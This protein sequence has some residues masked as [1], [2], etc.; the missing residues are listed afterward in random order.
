MALSDTV[1][2]CSRNGGLARRTAACTSGPAGSSWSNTSVSDL[3]VRFAI[4]YRR[5]RDL[6]YYLEVVVV[7]VLS[8][9][10]AVMD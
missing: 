10:A 8:I 1:L 6:A 9:I 4:Q 2:I 7:V 3:K 5:L